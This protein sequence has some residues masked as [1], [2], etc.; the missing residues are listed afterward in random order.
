MGSPVGSATTQQNQ[1]QSNEP[2]LNLDGKIGQLRVLPEMQ[3]ADEHWGGSESWFGR[4]KGRP[5][6]QLIAL[7]VS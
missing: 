3:A 5:N 7:P 4:A 2:Q 1:T 6:V